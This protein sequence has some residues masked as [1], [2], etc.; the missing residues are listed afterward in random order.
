MRQARRSTGAGLPRAVRRCA[1]RQP[2]HAFPQGAPDQPDQQR[3]SEAAGQHHHQRD[4]GMGQGQR[5][6]ADHHGVFGGRRHP[7]AGRFR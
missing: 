4:P 1:A 2:T 5:Q 6:T 7:V 3:A